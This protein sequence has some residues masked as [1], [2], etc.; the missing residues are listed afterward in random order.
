MQPFFFFFFQPVSDIVGAPWQGQTM[1]FTTFDGC[2]AQKLFP[3]GMG[4]QKWL[5]VQVSRWEDCTSKH[6][7]IL[8]SCN[9]IC[10]W[11]LRKSFWCF[12]GLAGPLKGWPG[13]R[14]FGEGTALF[15]V[16]LVGMCGGVKEIFSFCQWTEKPPRKPAIASFSQWM[17]PTLSLAQ[18]HSQLGNRHYERKIMAQHF[19][20]RGIMG[21][22]SLR[23]GTSR[24]G[25]AAELYFW[26]WSS[27][28]ERLCV[29]LM[30]Q[31]DRSGLVLSAMCS[32]VCCRCPNSQ[33]CS[34]FSIT[35]FFHC[36]MSVSL[37][38]WMRR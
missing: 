18:K 28:T 1:L 29:M 25:R 22:F 35:P 31:L 9:L 26:T 11:C 15:F 10:I 13:K 33:F 17:L 19:S 12:L 24:R 37:S 20:L 2:V 8:Q 21:L 23:H 7:C 38:L 36:S 4:S 14:M 27:I 3:S 34:A 5:Q 16:P 30:C 6:G 32:L